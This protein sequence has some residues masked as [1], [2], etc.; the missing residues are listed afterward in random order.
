VQPQAAPQKELKDLGADPQRVELL[1]LERAYVK[2]VEFNRLALQRFEPLAFS[3]TSNQAAKSAPEETHILIGGNLNAP[4]ERVTP[5][6]LSAPARFV[7]PPSDGSVRQ[8]SIPAEAGTTNVIP[9]A[10]AGRRLALARWIADP[11]NPL[12]ARV[13][14]NRVWQYHFGKG[15]VE[16]SN[17]F[18]KLGKR[19]SH[20]ELL[21]WLA[22]YFIERGWSMKAMH[23][24][25]MNSAAYQRSSRH[26]QPELV[27]KAD[28]ENKLLAYFSPRRIEAEV[29]RDSLLLVA[30]ELNLEMG[31]P[32][33]FPELNADLVAQP[34]LIMGTVAPAWEA[35]PER[36][37]RNRRTIYTFQQRSLINPLVEV[38]NGANL[39]ES[40]EFRR[41]S[42]VTPQVFNLFNSQFSYDMAL[43]FARRLESATSDLRKQIEL[44]F[45]LTYQ[46][47]PSANESAKA[48]A[49]VQA[50]T[51]HHS[52]VKPPQLAPLKPVEQSVNS[53]FSG[54]T[55]R[56]VEDTDFTNYERNLH[57]SQVSAQ[58]RALAELCL[59]LLNANEFVYL[60]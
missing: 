12:T 19:P 43:A 53:E 58:T 36:A 9:N 3:V 40:C 45:R 55:I 37:E 33:T 47:L 23:R 42:T 13:L 35:S 29:L 57:P 38:F 24:L 54:L 30:G 6:V 4:G 17:N 15:L 16:T 28:P 22:M 51:K 52:V 10:P 5:G 59:V 34:R 49:H 2:R 1:E 44:A 56:I 11:N 31:G 48:L 21:D 26:A 7:V 32:G 46:R 60:Y 8:L 27:A 25:L 14:V 18:G 50:M 41:T 39:N 20:P